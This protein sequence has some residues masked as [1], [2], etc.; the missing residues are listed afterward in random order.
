MARA[1]AEVT[2]REG[3][4]R[5]SQASLLRAAGCPAVPAD[6]FRL[7]RA[8]T[9]AGLFKTGAVLVG[10]HAFM[11]LGNQLGVVW[12]GRAATTQDVDV[13]H[14]R[15]V[16]LAVPGESMSVPDV[17]EGLQLG[18][19]PIPRLDPEQPSTSFMFRNRQLRL[20]LLTPPH[21]KRTA[22]IDIPALGAPAQVMRY[23]DFL[24]EAPQ[25]AILVG[26][27]VLR[28]AVPEPAR[29]AI[30]KLLISGDRPATESAKARKDLQQAG[31]LLRILLEDRPGDVAQPWHAARE[32]GKNWARR[33]ERGRRALQDDVRTGCA[34]WGSAGPAA[35]AVA[36][37]GRNQPR[38]RGP[39]PRRANRSRRI[40]SACS[41][42]SGVS[43]TDL[44]LLFGSVM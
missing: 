36:R 32:R 11:A 35:D 39:H 8:L 1:E 31:Q 30:H 12:P 40:R 44:A 19:Q 4:D 3:L 10:T 7:L 38:P 14:G 13:A 5:R 24:L 22:P 34:T 25:P 2:G 29:Y 27:S 21:G 6:A 20:D 9:D 28:V 41:R 42:P 33:L 15:S 43:W 16:E 18:Y 26:A 23:L 17:L 37:G